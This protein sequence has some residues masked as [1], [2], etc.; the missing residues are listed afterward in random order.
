ME[1]KL[2][3]ILSSH[4]P[5]YNNGK[6]MGANTPTFT[7]TAAPLQE[8]IACGEEYIWNAKEGQNMARAQKFDLDTV[9]EFARQCSNWGKWGA[10]RILSGLSPAEFGRLKTVSV[11]IRQT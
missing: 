10:E 2:T 5:P 9:K 1:R 7:L 3:A 6:T 8:V 11:L 4:D